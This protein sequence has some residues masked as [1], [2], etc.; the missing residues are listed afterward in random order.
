MSKAQRPTFSQRGSSQTP[1]VFLM[2]THSPGRTV[3]VE[4]SDMKPVKTL[5]FELWTLDVGG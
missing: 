1:I 2:S 5:D 3:G 4:L